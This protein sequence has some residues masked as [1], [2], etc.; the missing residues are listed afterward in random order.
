MKLIIEYNINNK[1]FNNLI[2][3]KYVYQTDLAKLHINFQQ[4]D[5]VIKLI[6]HNTLD[7]N[8]S[9]NITVPKMYSYPNVTYFAKFNVI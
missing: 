9:L 4:Y 5:N 3:K 6:K 1:Y 2:Y 8:R 7:V